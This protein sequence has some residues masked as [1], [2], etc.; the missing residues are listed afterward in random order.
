MPGAKSPKRLKI[1]APKLIPPEKRGHVGSVYAATLLFEFYIVVD[2]RPNVR[3]LCEER[4]VLIESPSA[5][6]ALVEARRQA[7]LSQHSYRNSYNTLI[8][9][10]FIGVLDLLFLGAE[11]E[12]NEVWYQLKT[13]VRPMERRSRIVPKPNEL[14]AIRNERK[15][16]PKRGAVRPRPR[17]RN[18]LPG[19]LLR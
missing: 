2:G 6:R 5:R 15:G 9:F 12:A 1:V 18:E 16:R 8:K 4:I 3:R 14:N 13:L 11:C 17:P 10:R 7:K 19:S